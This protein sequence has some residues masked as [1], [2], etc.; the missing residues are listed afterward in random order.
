MHRRNTGPWGRV[1]RPQAITR[2]KLDCSST[3]HA[4]LS[5][6]TKPRP[7][8]RVGPQMDGVQRCEWRRSSEAATLSST[9]HRAPCASASCGDPRADAQERER[10]CGV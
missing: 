8:V 9:A 3:T 4:C 2:T 10:V 5:G 1:N 6:D 7:R